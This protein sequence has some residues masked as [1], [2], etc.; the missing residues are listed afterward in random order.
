M[1]SQ[2]AEDRGSEFTRICEEGIQLSLKKWCA[3][4]QIV[5]HSHIPLLQLYQ[6]FLELH[7]ASQLFGSLGNTNAQNLEQRSTEIRGILGSWR[8]RLP[9]VWDDM[10]VW[11]QK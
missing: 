3:L 4:P 2:A 9:N 1:R 7:E 8:E 11:S 5:S 10:N 6:Q